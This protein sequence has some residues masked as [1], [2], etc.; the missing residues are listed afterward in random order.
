MLFIFKKNILN[1]TATLFVLYFAFSVQVALA[2]AGVIFACIGLTA[3]IGTGGDF[4]PFF[5]DWAERYE[6]GLADAK[7]WKDNRWRF[8]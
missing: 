5:P 1:I 7:E 3:V 6:A 8:F 2:S 4:I